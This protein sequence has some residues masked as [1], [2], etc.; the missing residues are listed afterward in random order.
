VFEPASSG[1]RADTEEG[2]MNWD[3]MDYIVAGGLVGVLVALAFVVI[4]RGPNLFYMAGAG[5]A[6][7]TGFVMIWASLAVG[8]IGAEGDAANLMFAGVL[9]I[10]VLGAL[11]SRFRSAGMARAM[12][13][14]MLA[15][16]L[17][18]GVA[19]A[20]GW[21]ADSARW[22]FDVLAATAVLAVM[23]LVSSWL[24]RASAWKQG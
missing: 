10:A 8:I 12:F 13:A 23:W 24:F 19:L 15:Q 1:R 2:A 20:A 18:G 16:L 14:A 11:W 6:A 21:G 4:L 7:L 5:L 3:L 22:P 17:A 9:V